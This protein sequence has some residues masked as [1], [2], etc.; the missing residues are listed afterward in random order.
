TPIVA[1]V[2]LAIWAS[3][4]TLTGTFDQLTT[5]I[6]FVDITIDLVA[7]ASIFVL[8]RSMPQMRRPYRTPWYPV[9]PILYVVTL[10]WLIITTLRTSPLEALGGLAI[11]AIGLPVYW[12]YRRS[13]TRIPVGGD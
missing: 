9:I 3:A 11:L 10:A 2:C 4:L 13:P 12:Y 8:R 5:L 1:I 6:I 7:A